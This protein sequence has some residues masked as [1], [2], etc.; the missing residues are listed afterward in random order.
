MII[1]HV[2]KFH[3]TAAA[4]TSQN[5]SVQ[6][7]PTVYKDLIPNNRIDML[8]VNKVKEV[9]SNELSSA[10]V[11]NKLKGNI[12]SDEDSSLYSDNIMK[13][14]QKSQ[15]HAPLVLYESDK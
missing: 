7:T 12:S 6:T 1:S 14:K 13:K 2:E 15:L 4:V 10:F 5:L 11:K 3:T 8:L 9:T